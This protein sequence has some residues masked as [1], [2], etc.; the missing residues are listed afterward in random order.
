MFA[1]NKQTI[2]ILQINSKYL[3]LMSINLGFKNSTGEPGG[4]GHNT[5]CDF[6]NDDIF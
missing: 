5:F 2:R 1:Q 3:C 4:V 6:Q